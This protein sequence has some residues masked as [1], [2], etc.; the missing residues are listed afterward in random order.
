VIEFPWLS[1]LNVIS[2]N[3][4]PKKKFLSYELS[5]FMRLLNNLIME[6]Y[7]G[8]GKTRTLERGT[9]GFW[10]FKTSGN[11]YLLFLEMLTKTPF[12]QWVT[13]HNMDFHKFTCQI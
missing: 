5:L 2:I 8:H 10:P 1:K 9:A 12:P 11:H 6:K 3:L 13:P 4:R 7:L